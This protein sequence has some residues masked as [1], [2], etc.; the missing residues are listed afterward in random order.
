MKRTDPGSMSLND[1]LRVRGHDGAP[2]S[3]GAL[4]PSL[5]ERATRYVFGDEADVAPDGPRL[6]TDGAGGD[7]GPV[8]VE[9]T[10]GAISGLLA[11]KVGLGLSEAGGQRDAGASGLNREALVAPRPWFDDPCRDG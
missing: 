1:S 11:S 3:C 9:C 4:R 6:S 7:R 10:R 2:R 8:G 5:G